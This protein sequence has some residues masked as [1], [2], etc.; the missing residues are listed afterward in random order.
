MTKTNFDRSEVEA[1]LGLINNA[2][3]EAMD[4][5]EKSGHGIPSVYSA[6]KHPL[7]T[8]TTSLVLKKAIR[9]LEGACEQLCST[10]APPTHTLLNVSQMLK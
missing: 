2:T 4:V 7:D 5:Y 10:L 9:V 1:L 8:E 6:Q 3:R